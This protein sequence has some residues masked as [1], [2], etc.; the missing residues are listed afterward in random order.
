MAI[1][2]KSLWLRPPSRDDVG[3]IAALASE[4]EVAKQTERIP[5]PYTA[6][7]AQRWLDS[8]IGGNSGETVFVVEATG[9]RQSVVGAIGLGP[10]RIEEEQELGFWIGK[11]YWGRGFATEAASAVVHF[12][13]EELGLQQIVA[14]TFRENRASRRVLEKI[15]FHETAL[16]SVNWPHR[17]GHR[18]IQRYAIARM[19]K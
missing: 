1:A 19:Q 13:F 14:G 6:I 12:G 7:D 10:A 5:H 4:W 16:A 8:V 11:P 17:G 2:T 9:E 15:V 3:S 18:Q